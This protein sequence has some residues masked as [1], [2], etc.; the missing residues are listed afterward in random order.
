M[1]TAVRS[2]SSGRS[3]QPASASA[4]RVQAIAHFWTSS[5]ASLTFGGIGSFQSSGS[6]SQSRTHP[7]IFEYGLS[8]LLR[9]R[10]VVQGRIPARGV[11][12]A[13]RVAAVGHVVPEGARIGR[14]GQ[15][16]P[17]TDDRDGVVG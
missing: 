13:D 9:I 1:I 3:G 4:I 8:G 17:D 12:L 14:V 6:H 2:R 15:D 10:V 5:I 7:P 16:R 11:D